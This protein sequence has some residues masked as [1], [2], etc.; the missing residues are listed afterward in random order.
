MNQEFLLDNQGSKQGIYLNQ[1][2]I[3]LLFIISCESKSQLESYFYKICGQFPNQK[4]E[5]VIPNYESMSLEEV[6][7]A[8]FKKYQDSLTDYKTNH[9]MTLQEQA[10]S[11]LTKMHL[12]NGSPIPQEVLGQVDVIFDSAK[13]NIKTWYMSHSYL[14]NLSLDMMKYLITY[15]VIV[16]QLII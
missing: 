4:L 5:D 1:Q 12:S 7:R 3:D 6:K 11:K 10:L 8:L 16:V 14:I 13:N 15:R 9:R 2:Q